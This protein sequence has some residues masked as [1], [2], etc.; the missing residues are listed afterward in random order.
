[1]TPD[2]MRAFVRKPAQG[3]KRLRVILETEEGAEDIAEWN[4]DQTDADAED[5][6]SAITKQCKDHT[7]E[8]DEEC[9]FYI[10]WMGTKARPLKGCV[11][12]CQPTT[13]AQKT[14]GETSEEDTPAMK[15][16]I[17][18]NEKLMDH[19][20][21]KERTTNDSLSTIVDVYGKSIQMLTGQL[22]QAHKLL[23]KIADEVDDT[24][25]APL[26][27]LTDE[28]REEVSQ[29]S[30]AMSALAD[31]IPSVIELGIAAAANKWLPPA[32]EEKKKATATVTNISDKKKE[33]K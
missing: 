2:R 30:R 5:I 13:V 17:R 15:V 19:L 8:L 10:Q 28:Q 1:M 9:K 21:A 32:P 12:R 20:D 14:A 7:N 27:V 26:A 31:Q 23:R 11:H 22:D 3:A 33:K 25:V 24:L 29:R 4:R 6:A 18:M 16:L